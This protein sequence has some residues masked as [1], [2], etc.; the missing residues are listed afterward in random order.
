MKEIVVFTDGSYSAHKKTCGCG[1][2]IP[3]YDAIRGKW[4]NFNSGRYTNQ[5]AE[6]KAIIFALKY[7][8][9]QGED[10][11][12]KKTKIIIYTDSQ[13]SILT[14]NSPNISKKLK[15]G[16]SIP[17]EKYVKELRGLYRRFKGKISLVHVHSHTK[18][19][20][21]IKIGNAI[22]DIIA[23]IFAE[24]K[25]RDIDKFKKQIE[26]IKKKANKIKDNSRYLS[27]RLK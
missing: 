19:D 9:K 21:G 13:Y 4:L 15:K 17:N 24:N 27:S 20:S 5:V 18:L 8:I 3:A 12:P 1:Y 22:V 6:L 14:I 7:L 16:I 11:N 23:K 26:K 2:Y 10:I 25:N